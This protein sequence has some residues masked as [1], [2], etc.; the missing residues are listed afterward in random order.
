MLRVRNTVPWLFLALIGALVMVGCDEQDSEIIAPESDSEEAYFQSV[1]TNDP[2]FTSEEASLN[3]GSALPP[4]YSDFMGKVS[5]EIYPFRF[6]RLIESVNRNVQF[7]RID[8]T[9]VV[10]TITKTIVGKFLVA[11]SYSDTASVPDTLIRKPFTSTSVREMKFFRIGR[12]REHHRNWRF[13]AIS[14]VEG[15]TNTSEIDITQLKLELPNGETIIVTSPTDYYLSFGNG[16]GVPIFSPG[17][18]VRLE[19]TLTSASPDSDMVVLRYGAMPTG[20]RRHRARLTMV[21]ETQ[22][23]SMYER[24]YE[25]TWRAHAHV[26]KFNAHVDAVTRETLYDDVAPVSTSFW[27]VPYI[28]Q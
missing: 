10:A 18:E 14:L 3:D 19:V 26:G 25:I 7:E 23:G 4:D 1:I 24:V 9:L 27:G 5:T 17:G 20:L 13:K 28:V 22:V 21:S 12:F 6:G 2:F 15:G 8:D 16:R 11:A